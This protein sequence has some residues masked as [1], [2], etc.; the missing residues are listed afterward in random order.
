M[1]KRNMTLAALALAILMAISTGAAPAAEGNC[2][3]TAGPDK[4]TLSEPAQE[5]SDSLYQSGSALFGKLH[6]KGKNMTISP[7]SIGMAMNMV[8]CGARG[9]TAEEMAKALSLPEWASPKKVMKCA[10]EMIKAVRTDG[11][12]TIETANSIWTRIKV[13]D[14]YVSD[15]RKNFDAEVSDKLSKEAVNKWVSKKTHEKIKE[16]IE[17][18]RGIEVILVNAVYFNGKWAKE[19]RKENTRKRDFTRSDGSKIKVDM[20]NQRSSTLYYE[21]DDCQMV[22]L[23]YKGGVSM[24]VLLP[25]EG[26]TVAPTPESVKRLRG[27]SYMEDV[28]VLLPKFKAEYSTD[29]KDAFE[30]LGMKKAFSADADFSGIR[31]GLCI[32]KVIHKTMVD[33]NESGTEAAAATAVTMRLGGAALGPQR[34]PKIFSA[35]RPFLFV[36]T[37]TKSGIPLFAGAVE[38]PEYK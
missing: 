8:Y 27:K 1:K 33:V 7:Y 15:C 28:I 19:F 34:Q 24:S 18:D 5:L 10:P 2:M 36:I 22:T 6:K 30:S 23:P 11:S 29:L 16:I 17:D 12:A 4:T 20:M 31:K 3:G 21:D 13:N 37:E 9:E 35:D 38:N 26:G 32:S 25:K 14:K